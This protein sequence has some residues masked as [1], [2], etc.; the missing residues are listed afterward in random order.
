MCLS[1]HSSTW[2]TLTQYSLS[3][4]RGG[5]QQAMVSE[6]VGLP[7][8]HTHRQPLDGQTGPLQGVRNDK[9]CGDGRGKEGEGMQV[10][11]HWSERGGCER[12]FVFAIKAHARTS[13]ALF[14]PSHLLL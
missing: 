1:R 6:Q 4:K 10:E 12:M 5:A 14:P 11:G 3:L 7:G 8:L 2:C 13:A 9:I